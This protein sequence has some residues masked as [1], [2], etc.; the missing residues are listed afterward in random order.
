MTS[1][2]AASTYERRC[3][4][5]MRLAYPPRFRE[6]RGAELLSTLMDLA[7]P[8]QSS[9]TL[10]DGLDVLRSGL[11]LRLRER[12]PVGHWLL[13]R[14]FGIQVPWEYR[15]WARDDIQ[16]QFFYERHIAST[17]L[18][19]S[20]CSTLTQL[21]TSHVTHLFFLSQLGASVV[22]Y[23]VLL[24]AKDRFKRR[25]LARHEFHPDGTSYVPI[26]PEVHPGGRAH[27]PK[28]DDVQRI[29]RLGP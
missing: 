22:V 10:R 21:L 1:S 11:M 14:L 17:M 19:T 6:F 18:W 16:G 7:E 24:P 9:P 26:P 15:W 23:L 20:L 12:P 5:L 2:D 29:K 28:P 25:W 4:L 13:Y 27:E 3:R 8:G